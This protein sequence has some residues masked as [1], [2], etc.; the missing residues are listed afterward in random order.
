MF[1][2]IIRNVTTH[3]LA[4]YHVANKWFDNVGLATY[5]EENH[6]LF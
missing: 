3:S 5:F 1:V 6:G 4:S 2:L